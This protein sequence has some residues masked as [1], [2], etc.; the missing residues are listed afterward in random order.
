MC[1][2]AGFLDL[3]RST[4]D[5]VLRRIAGGMAEPLRH[6]GPDDDGVWVEAEAGIALGH[7]RL[8]ILDLSPAGSQPMLSGNQRFTISYNGEV[9][10]FRAL[11][12]ELEAAGQSFRGSSDTEVILEVCAARGIETA[13]KSLNG[14]FAFALWDRQ[15]RSLTLVRDRLGI[16]GPIRAPLSIWIGTQGALRSSRLDA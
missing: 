4:S 14:M 3:S 9:Y 5:Q 1:G 13:V 16:L 2:I 12:A 8:S 7:R 6:R 10:N 15:T 11:R